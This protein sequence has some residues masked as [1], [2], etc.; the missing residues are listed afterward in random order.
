MRPARGELHE[1]DSQL[2]AQFRD[3]R[4]RQHR[5]VCLIRRGREKE[6]SSRGT[7]FLV[8]VAEGAFASGR[9]GNATGERF[10]DCARNDGGWTGR[11]PFQRSFRAEPVGGVEESLVGDEGRTEDEAVTNSDLRGD[12]RVRRGAP[13]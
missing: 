10:L 8:A 11:L 2:R 7:S 6:C 9:E 12:E 13:S 4:T 1:P 3:G 5:Q